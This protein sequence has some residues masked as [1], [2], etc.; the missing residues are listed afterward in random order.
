MKDRA[1]VNI[2][3]ANYLNE[4]LQLPNIKK[5]DIRHIIIGRWYYGL[6]LIAKNYL[7]DNK[8]CIDSPNYFHHKSNEE[9]SIYSIWHRVG[10]EVKD[11][12]NDIKQGEILATLRERYEYSGD[13][14]SED[15]FNNAER[16]FNEIYE[17]FK[18]EL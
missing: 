18:Y 13:L 5:Q 15:D 16:I 7:I 4:N 3:I 11:S 17:V 12:Y 6:F 9:N 14:C 2:K 10:N 8:K 1:E